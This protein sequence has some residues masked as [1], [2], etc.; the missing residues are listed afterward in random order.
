M[1]RTQCEP[2]CRPAIVYIA[3]I[4]PV[5]ECEGQEDVGLAKIEVV[6]KGSLAEVQT[7][8]SSF[9]ESFLA[10]TS[11]ASLWRFSHLLSYGDLGFPSGAASNAVACALL[12]CCLT[13]YAIGAAS[14][15]HLKAIAKDWLATVQAARVLPSLYSLSP[16]PTMAKDGKDGEKQ[17][18]PTVTA[19]IP[20]EKLPKDLQKIVDK[21]DDWM[22]DLYDGQHVTS[23]NFKC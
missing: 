13:P 4:S 10:K 2:I 18:P 9:G 20:R 8:L 5:K 19:P 21:S 3:T 6:Q 7:A 17:Y 14:L 1:G 16:T 15:E 11:Q 12:L 22:D 23:N